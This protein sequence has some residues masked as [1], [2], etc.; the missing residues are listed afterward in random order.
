[1]D[2]NKKMNRYNFS[3]QIISVS[4]RKVKTNSSPLCLPLYVFKK[5]LYLLNKRKRKR[6]KKETAIY[7]YIYIYIILG[8]LLFWVYLMNWSLSKQ[9]LAN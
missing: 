5:V 1:M 2:T 3:S 4:C 9:V 6:K 8:I 7:I